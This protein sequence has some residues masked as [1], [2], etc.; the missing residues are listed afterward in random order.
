MEDFGR[1]VE[2]EQRVAHTSML[3]RLTLARVRIWTGQL[4]AAR[5]ALTPLY[6]EARAGGLRSEFWALS[7]LVDAETRAGN[8]A[9]A[10]ELADEFG[11][12]SQPSTRMLTDVV[13]VLSSGLIAAWT[14]DVGRA[15][16][17][18]DEAIRRADVG[19]WPPRLVESRWVRGFVELSL[20]DSAAA[21]EYF[22]PAVSRVWQGGVGGPSRHVPLFRDDAAALAELGRPD[23][24]SPLIEWMERDVDNPW[25]QAAAAHSR[26]VAADAS[27]DEEQALAALEGAVEL[28]GCL[29]LPLEVGRALL[30]LGSAQRR[31]RVK[32]DARA[33]LERAVAI[34][35]ERGAPLW[36]ERAR[37]ELARIG[38]RARADSDLTASERRVA[39]L[40]AKGLTNKEVAHRLFVTDRTVEGHLSRIYAKLGVRSRA[41]LARR[42][43]APV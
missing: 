31:A 33:S 23:E 4:D 34:F 25:A 2:L 7:F 3:A 10:R 14:G 39:E 38:G 32:R 27:G 18:A 42:F 16:R 40:V 17:E 19:G 9:R 22:A 5:A 1:A 12:I 35:A 37:R 43:V 30:A 8:L 24:V 15:R 11:A 20:G 6:E 41:E 21:H 26:G 29:P 28:F 36:A 13:A